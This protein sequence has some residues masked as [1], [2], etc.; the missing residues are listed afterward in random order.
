MFVFVACYVDFVFR[1]DNGSLLGQS[2]VSLKIIHQVICHNTITFLPPAPKEHLA[3]LSKF[4]KVPFKSDKKRQVRY[5]TP[6]FL[7]LIGTLA[8]RTA[9]LTPTT[10]NNSKYNNCTLE[11]IALDTRTELSLKLKREKTFFLSS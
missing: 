6:S 8:T 4:V 7:S 3:R 1:Q 5:R 9:T 10:K 11:Y 2:F